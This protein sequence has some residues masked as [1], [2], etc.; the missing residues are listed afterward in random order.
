MANRVPCYFLPPTWDLPPPPLGP[1]GL[2]SVLASPKTVE[3]PLHTPP[4][5]AE[6]DVFSTTQRNFRF[7]TDKMRSGQLGVFTRF[8]SF[9]L[10]V[11][12]DAAVGWESLYVLFHNLYPYHHSLQLELEPSLPTFQSS[13][14]N[15]PTHLASYLYPSLLFILIPLFQP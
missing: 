1:L 15:I 14:C 6:G 13:V 9:V 5:P 8:L 10:G 12:V 2:G 3:R 11:G 7:S 4:P